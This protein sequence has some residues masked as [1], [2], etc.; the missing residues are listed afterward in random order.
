MLAGTTL[1]TAT[2][3]GLIAK[4]GESEKTVGLGLVVNAAI[5]SSLPLG[6]LGSEK[7]LDVALQEDILTSR[8]PQ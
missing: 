1:A 3:I 5:I 7:I 8:D 4:G 6:Y 2:G